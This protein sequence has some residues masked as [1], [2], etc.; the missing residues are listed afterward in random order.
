MRM[1]A[2]NPASKVTQAD[3]TCKSTLNLSPFDA[4]SY[5]DVIS[6]SNAFLWTQVES[7]VAIICVCLPTLKGVLG[8]FMPNLFTTK[9]RSIQDHYNLDEYSGGNSKSWRDKKS[10]KGEV[11]EIMEDTGSEERIMGIT[12]TV[13]VRVTKEY[14]Q[15]STTAG[16]ESFRGSNGFKGT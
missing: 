3:M 11:T 10:R 8:K 7:C 9:G 5:P 2:L 12:R 4:N 13:D 14:S 6:T 16:K 1:I 15:G